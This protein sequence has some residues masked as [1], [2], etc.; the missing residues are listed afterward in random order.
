MEETESA[1]ADGRKLLTLAELGA[2]LPLGIRDSSGNFAKGLAL[3]PW[4]MKEE[5]ELAALREEATG[6]GEMTVGQHVSCVLATMYTHFGHFDFTNM[7]LEEKRIVLSQTYMGDI[8]Y[9]YVYLRVMT[10]GPYLKIQVRCPRCRLLFPFTADLN[11][12]EVATGSS[13][14]GLLWD[15]DLAHPISIRGTEVSKLVMGPAR[16]AMIESARGTTGGD[17]KE[18]AIRSHIVGI[19]DAKEPLV[20]GASG[21]ELD[22][23]T[24][25]DIENLTNEIDQRYLGPNMSIEMGPEVPCLHCKYKEP[26]RLPLDWRYDSFFGTSSP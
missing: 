8:W 17:A 9:A 20:L 21:P 25:L 22:E 18:I 10:L 4:R 3:K 23:M 16:W 1:P 12:T 11:T 2:N 14:E 13:L 7:K 15:Y 5:K 26:T 19:N 24:K 6:G